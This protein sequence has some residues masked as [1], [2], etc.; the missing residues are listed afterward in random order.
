MTT[1]TTVYH[2]MDTGLCSRGYGYV[3]SESRL[4]TILCL[5]PRCL[6]HQACPELTYCWP[7]VLEVSERM[8]FFGI[9]RTE[10]ALFMLMPVWLGPLIMLM[11]M[12]MPVWLGPLFMLMLM[13]VSLGSWSLELGLR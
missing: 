5:T 8:D 10:R 2:E 11:L 13:P 4:Y 6:C 12:L 9:E 3:T 1:V 7:Q